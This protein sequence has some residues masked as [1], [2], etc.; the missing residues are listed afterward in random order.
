MDVGSE[1]KCLER[2]L[3]LT[4][5][6]EADIGQLSPGQ[7]QTL[8]QNI[9]RTNTVKSISFLVRDILMPILNN[10]SDIFMI[11]FL[12]SREDKSFAY[13]TLALFYLPT[14]FLFVHFL[15]HFKKRNHFILKLLIFPVIGPA[16]DWIINIYLLLR[17]K[18]IQPEL[19][20]ET[21][22]FLDIIRVV[23]G[24]IESSLQ[25]T[26][27]MVLICLE[28]SPLPWADMTIV[29]DI[30]GNTFPVPVST[31]SLLFSVISIINQL[32]FYWR[33]FGVRRTRRTRKV[34]EVEEEG[35]DI[36][37]L[38][39][40]YPIVL[41]HL[42]FRVG[43]LA[44]VSL[45]AN[46]YSVSLLGLGLVSYS[47]LRLTRTCHEVDSVLGEAVASLAN[48]IVLIP[49]SR[50]QTSHNLYF[51]HDTITN[52]FMMAFIISIQIINFDYNKPLF[53]RPDA[54]IISHDGFIIFIF[55]LVASF[56]LH[57]LV[58]IIFFCSNQRSPKKKLFKMKVKA[59]KVNIAKALLF[60][61]NLGLV[62]ATVILAAMSFYL[63][64]GSS[65]PAST[66]GHCGIWLQS[67]VNK[68]NIAPISCDQTASIDNYL[69]S[70][71]ME[72]FLNDS[73][74]FGRPFVPSSRTFYDFDLSEEDEKTVVAEDHWSL[75]EELSSP[76]V[77]IFL[78]FML[79]ISLSWILILTRS[80]LRKIIKC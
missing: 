58:R 55:I 74:C 65:P 18:K 76:A 44:L 12:W 78:C 36:S 32:S 11:I 46:I 9:K 10:I 19:D 17:R 15:L 79:A 23:N 34:E 13:M 53:I 60:L 31:L 38:F 80:H 37:C 33:T 64:P 75:Q 54:L 52:I 25:L 70:F 21:K 3:G 77:L 57:Y 30:L 73:D 61:V 39:L 2:R 63:S 26:W 67:A 5:D 50:D 62:V 56:I 43:V 51:I 4:G 6:I 28:V 41:T 20:E 45:F 7:G 69:Q 35:E 66:A 48:S 8:S 68:S 72:T 59:T 24:V 71:S 42:V 14:I 40:V 27:T 47:L 1:K 49:T 16:V 22:K 29:R